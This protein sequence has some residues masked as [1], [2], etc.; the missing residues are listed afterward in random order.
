M[1]GASLLY[2]VLGLACVPGPVARAQDPP[3]DPGTALR[4]GNHAFREGRLE[5][6]VEAYR[7]GLGTAE[8]D[9]VLAYNLGTALH[10]LG[11]LPE[12]VLWYRRAQAAGSADPWLEENLERARRDLGAVRLD[13]PRVLAPIFLHPWLAGV[14]ASALAWAGLFAVLLAPAARRRLAVPLLA[15]AVGVWA[16]ALALERFGPHPAVLLADCGPSLPAGS[17]VWG[18]EESSGVFRVSPTGTICP[19]DAAAP[20]TPTPTA[21]GR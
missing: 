3:P 1:R 16:G 9:P 14:L 7:R 8:V 4:E 15:A 20:V 19:G 11:R 13:P 17:E 18:V 21:G 12:A 5:A 10:R 6:A 2:L